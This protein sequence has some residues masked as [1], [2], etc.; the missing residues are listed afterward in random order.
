MTTTVSILLKVL[1]VLA[2]LLVEVLHDIEN[3][4]TAVKQDTG[5]Q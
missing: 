3:K 1:P 5:N 4:R 2:N